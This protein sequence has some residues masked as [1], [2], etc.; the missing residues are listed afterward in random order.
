MGYACSVVALAVHSLFASGLY[1]PVPL[2]AF[3]LSMGFAL[4]LE[5]NAVPSRD[6]LPGA[7]PR[8]SLPLWATL[9]A[10]PAMAGLLYGAA[11]PMIGDAYLLRGRRLL[12]AGWVNQAIP[13]LERAARLAPARAV[14]Q[15]GLAQAYFFAGR[16]PEGFAVLER[17]LKYDPY[18]FRIHYVMG[19]HLDQ[20]GNWEAA[21]RAYERA[22]DS[23]RFYSKPLLRIGLIRERRGDVQGAMEAYRQALQR[24]PGF[25]EASNNLAILLSAQGRLDEAIGVLERAA[26]ETPD[27][28]ILA[29]N[30]AAAYAKK[31]ATERAEF[32]AARAK[33]TRSMGKR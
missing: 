27:D 8:R 7:V 15:G 23:N 16:Q 5:G 26:R 13:V 18:N 32:W 31:G 3:W 6:Q 11:W 14:V 21:L 4:R 20:A 12:S 28:P 2:A 9:V 22:R 24:N 10:V 33:Q 29:Q 17:Y 19:E 1:T 25:A 30:L